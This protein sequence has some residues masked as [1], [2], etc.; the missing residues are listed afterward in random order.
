MSVF[1]FTAL[2]DRIEEFGREICHHNCLSDPLSV[3]QPSLVSEKIPYSVRCSGMEIHVWVLASAEVFSFSL[4]YENSLSLSLSLSPP[5]L[6]FT[7]SQEPAVY[8]GQVLCEG[9]GHLNARSC[10]LEG[11]VK[12]I[13]SKGCCVKMEIPDNVPC[14]LFPGQVHVKILVQ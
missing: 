9:E 3:A 7:H 13:R 12:S 14:S 2:L 10:L 8:T 11:P 5:P 6:L 4:E 1:V